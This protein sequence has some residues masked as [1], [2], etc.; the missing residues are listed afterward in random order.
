ML[1]TLQCPCIRPASC[2]SRARSPFAASLPARRP[3]HPEARARRGHV[4]P[5]GQIRRGDRA[6]AVDR[7][8]RDQRQ[9][10]PARQ[11]GRADRARRREQSRQG[12]DR[13][14][15]AGAAR[16]GRGAVRRP[17]HAG[18]AGHRAVRQPATRCR[19]WAC[20][21]PARRSRATA[22]PRTTC[23]ASRRSTSWWTRRWSTTPSPS[24]APRSPA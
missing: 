5:V 11:E 18:V 14:A 21:R 2:C 19:S 9:G 15:R 6:R 23:S 3:G 8:R 22:P 24:T 7:H 20:G 16:E 13:R 1:A 10:R 12:R 4:G 17:R